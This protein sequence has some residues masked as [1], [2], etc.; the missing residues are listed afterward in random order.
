VRPDTSYFIRT[1]TDILTAGTWH[2][3]VATYDGANLR[4]YVD[5]IQVGDT[6][7]RTGDIGTDALSDLV[8]F[9]QDNAGE[10]RR[11][12]DITA[13]AVSIYP[14][15]LTAAQVGELY[16]ATFESGAPVLSLTAN[17][18]QSIEFSWTD[19]ETWDGYQVWR[20]GT[21]IDTTTLKTYEDTGLSP[22]TEYS[23]EV[24]GY[25]TT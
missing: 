1:E 3:V 4:L 21:L 16:D 15:G 14:T 12:N 20:N 11:W 18:N 10:M 23:Y 25:K 5:K 9:A 19:S 24:R 2:H 22:A 7:P 8:V 13:A 6:V 17:T